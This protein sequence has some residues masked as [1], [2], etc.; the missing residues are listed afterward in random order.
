MN[1]NL[2]KRKGI[3]LKE[4]DYSEMGL[5]FVTICTDKRRKILSNIVGVDVPDDPIQRKTNFSISTINP[6]L[7]SIFIFSPNI[8]D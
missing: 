6:N 8:I 1:D 4:Y 7:S 3:R 5:Y 2:P